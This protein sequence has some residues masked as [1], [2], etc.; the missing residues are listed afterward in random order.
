MLSFHKTPAGGQRW[1]GAGARFRVCPVTEI[2]SPARASWVRNSPGFCWQEGKVVVLRILCKEGFMG[3]SW[4]EGTTEI[5]VQCTS[6]METFLNE[7][8]GFLWRRDLALASSPSPV[9]EV[10]GPRL[11]MDGLRAQ[12]AE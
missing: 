6:R 12:F 11:Q 2:C 5:T 8:S 10:S 9:N 3:F 4:L 7:A 1:L